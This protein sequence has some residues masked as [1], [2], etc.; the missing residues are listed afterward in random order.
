MSESRGAYSYREIMSQGAAWRASIDHA[1]PQV[2]SYKDW[3]RAPRR[4]TLFIG[5]GSTYYLSLAAAARWQSITG[6]PARGVPSSEIWLFPQ[7]QFSDEPPLLIAVSRSGET[8][9]TL[10]AIDVYN[11]RFHSPW[12]AITC[13][14]QSKMALA[15][16]HTLLTTGAEEQSIAQTRSFSS[17]L[18][19]A[20]FAAYVAAGD[21]KRLEELRLLPLAFDRLVSHYE[22]LAHSLASDMNLKHFVFLG[23]GYHYGLAC[24]AMLKAKEMSLTVSEAFHFLEF[25]HGPKSVVTPQTL[26][27]GL[28]SEPAGA[29]ENK[30]LAEMRAL[31]ARVVA[32][33]ETDDGVSADHVVEVKSGANDLARGILY[34]PFL[35]LLAYHRSMQNGLNPDQPT[36]LDAV[37]FL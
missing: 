29:E 12:M 6:T 37:V 4:E 16:P 27:V 32:I 20:Q 14:P 34:L 31:G 10:R 2:S 11:E 36:N 13:Y 28:L 22:P 23:S 8:S 9:E 24:E 30:V 3:L 7:V 26:V 33:A 18:L 21:Q 19:M 15:S 1:S 5:C 17:M 25:R 35:Q